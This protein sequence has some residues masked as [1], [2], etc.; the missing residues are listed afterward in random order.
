M[1]AACDGD[2]A[3]GTVQRLHTDE[4]W[5]R[6]LK[7]R[8]TKAARR[9]AKWCKRNYAGKL[10]LSECGLV[11]LPWADLRAAAHQ[12]VYLDVS[13]NVLMEIPGD[14]I[15]ACTA[16]RLLNCSFNQLASLPAEL[17][18][19]STL[20]Y[21]ICGHN[22]LS[23]LPAELGAC[24]VLHDLACNN[25][26]LSSLPAELGACT[27]LHRVFC[28]NNRLE[29]LPA[30]LGHCTALQH[31][32]C[33][34]NQLLALPAELGACTA[35]R[36][37]GCSN[38]QLSSL[39]DEL[40]KCTELQSLYCH[41]NQ[42]SSL[43]VQLGKLGKL[44]RVQCTSNLFTAGAPTTLAELRAAALA[45]SGRHTKRATPETPAEV[46]DGHSAAAD[47]DT[48]RKAARHG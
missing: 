28:Y 39:P 41:H 36:S 37:L 10:D 8:N 26:Q 20:R 35:L 34:N 4:A 22:Q 45:Q 32:D 18:A 16:L 14:F 1:A 47:G 27:A 11:S 48:T 5:A 24:T 15:A 31:L 23:A 17:G 33:S 25:N 44:H 19:C 40:G 30:E 42:L 3:E 46:G 29:A 38:N 43:P 12:I 9:F 7:P 21:L 6:H 13:S 2:A